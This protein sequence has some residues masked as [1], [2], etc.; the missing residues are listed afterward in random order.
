[1][2]FYTLCKRPLTPPPLGFT[3]SCCGFFDINVKKCVNVCRDK[4]WHN[5][6]KICGQNVKFT[7]KLWQFYPWK[8]FF[9]SILCCQKASWIIQIYNINFY[10]WVRSPPTQCVKIYPIWQR[11]ASLSQRKEIMAG[12]GPKYAF[13]TGRDN[14][15]HSTEECKLLLGG[16]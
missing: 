8:Y 14:T 15:T 12:R 9:V 1:M 3:R 6:A 7:L 4:I 13:S 10:T 16:C 2:F 5:I 11:M